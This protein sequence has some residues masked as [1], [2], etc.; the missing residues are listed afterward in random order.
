MPNGKYTCVYRRGKQYSEYC[1]IKSQMPN[2]K[3]T[4]VYQSASNL[5]IKE[6]QSQMPNGKYTC[7]YPLKEGD[8]FA[9]IVANA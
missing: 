9:E 7:V 2:G 4:C 8:F 6:L 5:H 1:F 3:Y